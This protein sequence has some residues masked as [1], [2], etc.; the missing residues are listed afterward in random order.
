MNWAGTSAILAVVLTASCCAQSAGYRSAIVWTPPNV[1]WPGDLP[2]STVPTVPKEMIGKLNIGDMPIIFEKTKLKDVQRRFG[3]S[4]GGHGDAGDSLAW[5]CFHSSDSF[6]PWV[7]WLTS[8]ELNGLSWIDG[9]Q[10]KRLTANETPDHRCA[11]LS[12]EK[13]AVELPVRLSLGLTSAEVRQVLGTPTRKRPDALFFLSERQLVIHKKE[14]TVWN[15]ITVFF[16]GSVACEI[17]VV[18]TTSS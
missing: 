18:K 4:I 1:G 9:F 7:L 13:S 5:L 10:W 6:G 12:K 2:T 16:R 3:G 11:S 17:D 14:Y 15:S 8:G